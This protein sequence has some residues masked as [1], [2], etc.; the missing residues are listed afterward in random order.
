MTIWVY[1]GVRQNAPTYRTH[2]PEVGSEYAH[3]D[4]GETHRP[5]T[6]RRHGFGDGKNERT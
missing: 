6:R 1:T 2:H 4:D 5:G 3:G